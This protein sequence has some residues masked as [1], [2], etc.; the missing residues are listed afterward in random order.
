MFGFHFEKYVCCFTLA[1]TSSF[2]PMWNRFASNK[3]Y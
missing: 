3:G 2:Y 1:L